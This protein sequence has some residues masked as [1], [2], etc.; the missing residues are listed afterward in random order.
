MSEEVRKRKLYEIHM[1]YDIFGQIFDMMQY[2]QC[3][4][5]SAMWMDV[6]RTIGST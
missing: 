5:L 1:A 2:Y 3:D 4:F 6:G